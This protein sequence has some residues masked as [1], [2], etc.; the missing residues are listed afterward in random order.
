MLTN[1]RALDF[2]P[3]ITCY[4]RLAPGDIFHHSLG[5]MSILEL[6]LQKKLL[7]QELEAANA[8]IIRLH[9]IS[10]KK[11]LLKKA[12]G[13]LNEI[14]AEATLTYTGLPVAYFRLPARSS[15]VSLKP[16]GNKEVKDREPTVINNTELIKMR[17]EQARRAAMKEEHE[18]VAKEKEQQASQKKQ[19]KTFQP[20]SV[21]PSLL[22]LRYARS[23]LPCTLEHGFSGHY[24]SWACP[25]QNLDYEY[26]LPFFFDGLQ[27]KEY[28]VYFLA[29]QGIEDLLFAAKGHPEWILPCIPKLIV[30]IR[31]AFFKFDQF[32]TLGTLKALQQLLQCNPGIGEALLPYAKQFLTP[33]K[34]F[35]GNNKNIGDKIDYGQRHNDDIGGQVRRDF[36]GFLASFPC[37]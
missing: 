7:L 19:K 5:E 15:K 21:V 30:P 16:I 4:H 20:P 36:M 18:K 11:T 37:F 10:N 14:P 24:L 12:T 33:V 31:N 27:C 26:Y 17:H 22:P 29:R 1:Y 8:K 28:P 35:F 13:Q 25:L 3:L 9:D 2:I 23:E 32:L 6:K 34:P